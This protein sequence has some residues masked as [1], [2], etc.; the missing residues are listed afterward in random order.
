MQHLDNIGEYDEPDFG[1]YYRTN[2]KK[3]YSVEEILEHHFDYTDANG[4]EQ[5][6]YTEIQVLWE[7]VPGSYSYDAPSDL[8]FRG[9]SEI[10]EWFVR[11]CTGT[12]GDVTVPVDVL[13]GSKFLRNVLTPEQF[14]EYNLDL[15]KF[16]EG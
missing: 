15:I 10:G 7:V 3:P 12:Y 5:Q 14:Q 1:D 2:P 13:N 11:K 8:D 16:I 9:Y 6:I 4:E